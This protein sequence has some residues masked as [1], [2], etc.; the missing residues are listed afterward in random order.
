MLA[1]A[2]ATPNRWQLTLNPGT[3]TNSAARCKIARMM[4]DVSLFG[5]PLDQHQ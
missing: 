2:S 1:S 3:A 4:P 5:K